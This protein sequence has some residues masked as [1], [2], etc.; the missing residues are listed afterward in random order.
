VCSNPYCWNLLAYRS[1]SEFDAAG[2]ALGKE[3]VIPL[4]IGVTGT[5]YCSSNNLPRRWCQ[6]RCCRI[7][8]KNDSFGR[9]WSSNTS[10]GTTNINDGSCG[11]VRLAD[12]SNI[13]QDFA[14]GTKALST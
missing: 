5:D 7:S 12:A 2:G 14:K 8:R 6:Q 11:D 3:T 9:L 13:C 1:T 4:T 10:C